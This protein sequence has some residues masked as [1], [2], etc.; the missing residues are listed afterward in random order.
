[1]TNKIMTDAEWSML[2][3]ESRA[4]INQY[5]AEYEAMQKRIAELESRLAVACQLSITGYASIKSFGNLACC[6]PNLCSEF[7]SEV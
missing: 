3:A 1:M 5:G 7:E 6:A 2:S 4:A